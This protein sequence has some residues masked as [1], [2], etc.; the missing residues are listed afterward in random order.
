MKLSVV[1][2]AYNESRNITITI[3]EILSVTDT[4]SDIDK[5]E[6]IVVDDHS[7]DETFDAVGRIND[8]RVSCLRLSKRSGSHTALRAGIR[9]AKG[10]AVLCITA[11]GQDNP[12]CI[13]EMLRKW[14][15]GAKIIWALRKSRKNE[16]WHIRVPALLFYRILNWVAGNEDNAIDLASAD[17]WLLDRVA[18]DAINACKE[19][20]TSL[21]GLIAWL[22][23]KQD[24]VEYDRRI[25]RYGKSKWDFR[26]RFNLARDWIIA[27]SGLPLRIA[28][29]FGILTAILGILYAVFV[30]INKLFLGNPMAGYPSIVV[31]ILVLGG[32]Q[33]TILGIIGEY[34]WR[35]LDE[36]RNRPLY[37]IERRTTNKNRTVR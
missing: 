29:L 25:R 18:V 5:V 17:F 11:D 20:N 9:E 6:I 10:D 37:F 34:L 23:F 16:A 15:M 36:T 32:V 26:S 28:S 1:I 14:N 7:S 31:L 24:F 2:P 22:G 19:R 3:E 33:L 30:I 13:P 21:F 4:I 12:A 8:P 27:F 35:N